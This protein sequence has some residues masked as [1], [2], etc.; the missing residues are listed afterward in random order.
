[1]SQKPVIRRALMLLAAVLVVA[2]GAGGSVGAQARDTRVVDAVKAGDRVALGRLIAAKANVNAPEPDGTTA[3]HWAARQGRLDLVQPLLRAGA[4][5]GAANRFGV[6]PIFL[7]AETGNEVA[8]RAL[9]EAGASATDVGADGQTVLMMAAR[10]GRPEAVRLLLDRGADPNVHETWQGETALMWAAAEN[11]AAVVTLLA[12]RGADVNAHSKALEFPKVKTDFATMVF[13]QMPTGGMTPLMFA[14][15]QGAMDAVK[16]L[17]AAKADLNAGDP[18]KTTA[19]ILAIINAHYD[20]AATLLEAGANPN[21]ADSAGMAALYAAVDMQHMEPL[22]NRPPA[23]PSGLL[24]AMDVIKRLLDKGADPNQALKTPLLMRLHNFGDASLG[25]GATPLMRVAKVS[26]AGLMRLLLDKGANPNARMKNGG[27]AI[28]VAASRP[29]RGAPPEAATIA[30]IAACLERGADVNAVNENG[31]TA[32]HVAVG[33]GDGL[34]KFLAEK[35]ARL[36]IKDKF[37][38]TP[39]DVAMGVPG[40][41]GGRRGGGGPPQPGPVRES[42][43]ALLKQLMAATSA[44]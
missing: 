2:V 36:D 21:I 9:L 29:G 4:K 28:M 23:K 25:E 6:T 11:H 27:T 17:I 42:T 32:L 5:A 26:D 20:V 34:V 7:A 30:A 19:L 33:R 22:T 24:S 31:E 14:A 12:S 18:D 41:G 1:M 39:L 38:R 44:R 10:T 37:G 8:M 15:R 43:A 3:L 13:I 40:G 16:A 35:G